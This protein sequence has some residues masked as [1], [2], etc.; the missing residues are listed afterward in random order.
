MNFSSNLRQPGWGNRAFLPLQ[1]PE[2][3][4]LKER[5]F[6]N[7]CKK[8][9][10]VKTSPVRFAHSKHIIKTPRTEENCVYFEYTRSHSEASQEVL[11]TWCPPLS[12]C[13]PT[14]RKWA[15]LRVILLL[16]G[17][18]PQRVL[19]GRSVSSLSLRDSQMPLSLPLRREPRS[20]LIRAVIEGGSCL[21]FTWEGFFNGWPLSHQTTL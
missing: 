11:G 4:Q 19:P 14:P 15:A 7:Y 1:F 6:S 21:C 9:R 10:A 8:K 13:A 2:L 18:N 16:Q 17:N 3:F 20:Y 5:T 12:V